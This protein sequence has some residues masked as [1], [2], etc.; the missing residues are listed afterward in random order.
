MTIDHS[1][2]SMLLVNYWDS[3]MGCM[4]VRRNPTGR[5]GVGSRGV[6]QGDPSGCCHCVGRVL[7]RCEC[8]TAHPI[9]SYMQII[10]AAHQVM[11]DG[12]IAPLKTLTQPERPITK[13]PLPLACSFLLHLSGFPCFHLRHSFHP[14]IIP[15]LS[16]HPSYTGR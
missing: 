1:E 4:P 2:K 12:G 6:H 9:T 14:F 5:K 11:S 7:C 8:P 10:W 3:T 13:A 15:F 16:P